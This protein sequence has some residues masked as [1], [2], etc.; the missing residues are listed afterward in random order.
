MPDYTKGQIPL[1]YDPKFPGG[2]EQTSLNH[3]TAYS[4]LWVGRILHVDVETMVC[5]IQMESGTGQWDDVPLPAPSGAGPRFWSGNIP[6]RGSKVLVGWKRWGTRHFRPYILQFFSV[7]VFSAREFEPFSTID[8]ADASS[9]L[10]QNPELEDDPRVN[11]NVIRLRLRKAYSGDYL[12]SSAEGSDF[13]LDRNA[14]LSNRVG[15]TFQL[16]DSDQTAVLQ[17]INEYTNNA[18]GYYR[19]GLVKRTSFN[20]LPDLAVSGFIPAINNY[21]DY[22]KNKL[23]TSDA[24]DTTVVVKV[25]PGSAAYDKLLEFGLIN[26]AGEPIFIN[27]ANDPIYPFVVLPDGQR[28]SY[29]THGEHEN[30]FADTDQCYIED[31]VELR[32]TSDG[33]MA[34]TE[35]GDGVQV[36]VV[37]PIF[38]EQVNGTVVGNDPYTEAGRELY[39]KILKMH[40]FEGPEQ[41]S[42][43]LPVLEPVDTVTSQTEADTQ[44]LAHL[45]RLISPTVNNQLVYGITKEG[46]VYL[47]VPKT[48]TGEPRD[49]GKSIDANILGLVKAIIGS[50][51]N[52]GTS[53]DLKT[54]G[55]MKLDIGTFQNTDDPENPEQISI[56]LILRGK[57]RTTY[58]GTQGRENIV[59]GS[60]FRSVSG[61]TMDVVGG[62]AVRNVG[63]SEAVEASSITHNSGPGGYKMKSA[64]N[65]NQTILGETDELYA[66][67]RKVTASLGD[68]KKILTGTDSTTVLAG[69]IT[70]SVAV[71]SG[72]TDSVTTGN[73]SQSVTTGNMSQS[74]I[75][76]NMSQSVAAGNMSMSAAAG[77]VSM[78]SGLSTTISSG[79]V[80]S[81]SSPITKIGMTTVGVAVAG[82][83]GPPGPMLDYVTGMPLRGIP[84]ISIG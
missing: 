25:E 34:V 20:L 13:L 14:T 53:L 75:A 74:V 28:V 83:P 80:T 45:F 40:I 62:N 78:S 72:I 73:M 59:G 65:C 2:A 76:G 67:I 52:T 55:G 31:R 11:L 43:G 61:S 69:G 44:A 15:N 66:K 79:T 50:D 12:A 71:G 42:L 19:R 81:I 23:Q 30:S 84:T 10:E 6:Q 41:G 37:P 22:I 17:T 24:G 51:E 1:S 49:K 38:I 21:E 8:P 58:L 48:Q 57:I 3:P 68:Q 4:Y 64:G 60:D 29:I 70:R 27:N 35:E 47:H 63:G 7:G 36:D 9:A 82:I 32:H 56:N 18:A 33:V 5:S 16:R 39:K 26:E 54:L 77:S 46:R